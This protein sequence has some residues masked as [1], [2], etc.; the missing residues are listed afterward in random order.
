[1]CLSDI[2]SIPKKKSSQFNIEDERGISLITIFK[3]A[4]E[5]LLFKE[6]RE[7]IDEN[8]SESNIGARKKRN[9]KDHL[10]I[11]HGIVSSVVKEQKESIDIQVFDVQKAF[12][13]IWVEDSLNEMYDTINEEN[14]NEKLAL[15]YL[16]NKENHLGIRTSFGLTSRKNV[17]DICQQGGIFGPTLCSVSVDS[18]GR[19]CIALRKELY[20]YRS[21]VNILPLTYIDDVEG[22]AKCG[23][24]SKN[25][26]RFITSEIEAKNL[27]FNEGSKERKGKCFQMHVGK[28]KDKCLS[29]KVHT[30]NMIDSSEI[31][32][33]GEIISA[34]AKNTKNVKNRTSKGLGLV[35][36]IMDTLDNLKL[37]PFYFETAVM[38]RNAILIN[39]MANNIEVWHNVTKSEVK[40]LET[41]DRL[42]LSNIFGKLP[43]SMPREC[44]YLE[45]G[46]EELGTIL[47]KR[48]IMYFQDVVSRKK[49]D[50]LYRFLMIQW[51]GNKK[52]D[53]MEMVRED[54]EDFSLPKEL[55]FYENF[56]RN[57]FKNIV[58][59]QA[60]SYSLN[61]LL[62]DKNS[63]S[64]MKHL[65]YKSLK[66]QPYLK[67]KN[68]SVATWKILN[69]ILKDHMT[70][71][72]VNYVTN[73]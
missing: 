44:F 45:L 17:P 53:F 3:K 12:D 59:N 61:K 31:V 65:L 26:N 49:K 43:R 1:M 38:L 73:I 40:E 30:T 50:M 28:D 15:V 56:D 62:K 27:R 25:L 4:F 70:N 71:Y 51:H 19:K 46:L 48:R 57:K 39:G 16:M 64:K 36:D 7:D 68:L 55:S 33:L 11:V 37:G 34:D 2:V 72:H 63:H 35:T 66:M 67:D 18:L 52:G 23:E 9:M 8:M 69:V 60:K 42:L 41:V 13:S 5:N 20:Q 24:E 54:L 47:K 10:V 29:L 58:K 32:Y 22:G 21:Q 6:F 14:R